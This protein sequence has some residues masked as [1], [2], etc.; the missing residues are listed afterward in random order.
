[1]IY[2][3]KLFFTITLSAL[4]LL[5]TIS[6]SFAQP[7][8]STGKWADKPKLVIGI[9]I[10]QMRY[11]YL[12][13]Y[14]D[15]FGTDG[16]N[17]LLSEGFLFRDAHFNYVPT[18]TGPGHAAVYTGATPSYSGIISNFWYERSEGKT[19]YVTEDKTVQ[20]VGG[21][22][23]ESQMSP[24]RLLTT[25][26]TDELRLATNKQSKVIGISL[27]DRGA[28]LPAGHIPTAAYWYDNETGNWIS[29]T[30]YTTQL[31]EWVK[32]FNNQKLQDVYLSK[33]WTTLYPL[34]TYKGGLENGSAFRNAYPG[35]SSN[36]FPHDLP[37]A[38]TTAGYELLRAT[39]FGNTYTL[40]FALKTI[41]EEQLGKRNVTDF[42]AI[43]FSST[44]YIGH[45]FGIQSI[46]VQD[47]YA[48]MDR[49]IARL[50]KYI[51]QYIGEKN[52]LIFLTADHGAVETPSQ[53]QS[54]NIPEGVFN[55][56]NIKSALNNLL[57][58][59]AA[60]EEWVSSFINNQ[61]YLNHELIKLKGIS[62]AKVD[63]TVIDYL[64]TLK[65]VYKVSKT[66]DL[67]RE[68]GDE[69]ARFQQNGIHPLRSGDIVIQLLPGW[70][71]ASYLAAGGTT[72]GTGYSYDT[73]VPVIWYGWKVK[74][75][76]SGEKIFITDI[77]PTVADML[78]INTPNGSEGKVLS[79]IILTK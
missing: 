61:V 48:R 25:T 30:Y 35:E 28:I 64:K 74:Q 43:S 55:G 51:D 62:E 4:F 31:P 29:S 67:F 34:E 39:P 24:R 5:T 20:G 59:G 68:N 12:F 2:P 60:Q 77:A 63:S 52:I 76:S 6:F 75:G 13:R 79:D 72:H 47:T 19:V 17:R 50:L 33:P 9:I 37:K 23:E 42:L 58:S 73:H 15:K 40:D 57:N 38:K 49:E 11:D 69:Q 3:K 14:S 22:G 70:H 8:D 71:D 10:D 7:N 44:D 36:K 78:D 41:E 65:G 26:I 66:E 18:Y 56:T 45:Q 53:M 54:L 46:E 27:K 16:F 32:K 1:M 21:T